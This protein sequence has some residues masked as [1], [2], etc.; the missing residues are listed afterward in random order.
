[1]K[2]IIDLGRKIIICLK[3]YKEKFDILINGE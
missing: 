2:K 3:E 1:M